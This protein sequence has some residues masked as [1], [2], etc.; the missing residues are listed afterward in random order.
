MVTCQN[1]LDDTQWCM[2]LYIDIKDRQN[3]LRC[4]FQSRKL[5]DVFLVLRSEPEFW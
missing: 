4:I 2:K 1:S 3:E 5:S